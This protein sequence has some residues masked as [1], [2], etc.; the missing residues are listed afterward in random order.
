MELYQRDEHKDILLTNL[1]TISRADPSLTTAES[2]AAVHP[3]NKG[4]IVKAVME[5]LLK[6]K[7]EGANQTIS[8]FFLAARAVC[9]VWRNFEDKL[10]VDGRYKDLEMARTVSVR[11][12]LNHCFHVKKGQAG[13][14]SRIFFKYLQKAWTFS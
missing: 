7:D 12:R 4:P 10:R 5:F 9:D 13:F 6:V 3:K 1:R 14:A 2:Y 8:D 11:S